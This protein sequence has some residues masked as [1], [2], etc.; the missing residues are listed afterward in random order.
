MNTEI[1]IGL[2][3][4]AITFIVVMPIYSAVS[5]KRKLKILHRIHY[6]QYGVIMNM[7]REHKN[8]LSVIRTKE[9]ENFGLECMISDLKT[10]IKKL[11]RK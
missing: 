1:L 5:Y 4:V 9:D 3:C 10:E 7:Q 11:K 2:A 6:Q 8:L